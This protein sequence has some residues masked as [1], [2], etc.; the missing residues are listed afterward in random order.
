MAQVLVRKLDERV[1]R[2]LKVRARRHRRSLQAELKLALTELADSS[3]VDTESALK[4]LIRLRRKFAGRRF[5]DS[6][7]SL[8]EER[9]R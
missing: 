6:L 3:A 7:Q 4:E 9:E 1:I 5:P 2:Q 8:R